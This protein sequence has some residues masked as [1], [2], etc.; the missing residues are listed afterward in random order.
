MVITRVEQQDID[1]IMPLYESARQFMIAR[2]NPYQ[3]VNGYPSK[4]VIVSDINKGIL[5]KCIDSSGNIAAVFCYYVGDEPTYHEIYDGEWLNSDTYGV[6][7]RI[8]SSGNV[9]RVADYCLEWCYSL[10]PNMRIDTHDDN[11]VMQRVLERCGY[12]RCGIIKL[13]N[14]EL[15]IAFHK[16]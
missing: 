1:Q 5:Y 15:R 9:K 4:D 2:G 16:C 13:S 8:A 14:G 6:V 7:H 10:H 12:K 11:I 3:W